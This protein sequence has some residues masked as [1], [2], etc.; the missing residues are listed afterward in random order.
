MNRDAVMLLSGGL[1]SATALAV[2][3]SEGFTPHALSFSYGQRHSLELEAA[4]RVAESAGVEDH[5]VIEIDL[6]KW[7]G[8]AL[9]ADLEVRLLGDGPGVGV[10]RRAVPVRDGRAG[11]CRRR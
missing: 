8:S 1:D 10:R 4:K 7:G 6:R 5:I 2:A 3:V 11:D 9:T